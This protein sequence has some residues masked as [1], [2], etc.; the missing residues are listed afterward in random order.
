MAAAPQ[1][2]MTTAVAAV[3]TTVAVKDLAKT[4]AGNLTNRTDRLKELPVLNLHIL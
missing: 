3:M 1:V 4:D 2:A